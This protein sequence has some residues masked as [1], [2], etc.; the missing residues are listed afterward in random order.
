VVERD[1]IERAAE[2]IAGLAMDAPRRIA[3]GRVAKLAV[4]DQRWSKVAEKVQAIYD[5]LSISRNRG[6]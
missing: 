4:A 3:M 6:E 2:I 1:D 5:H